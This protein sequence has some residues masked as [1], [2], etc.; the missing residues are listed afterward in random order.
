MEPHWYIYLDFP[1]GTNRVHHIKC[2]FLDKHRTVFKSIS[3]IYP[4]VS[5]EGVSYNLGQLSTPYIL[6]ASLELLI[7]CLSLPSAGLYVCTAMSGFGE[8]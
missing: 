8:P 4:F 6:D 2:R 7:L 3:P 1:S 5:N